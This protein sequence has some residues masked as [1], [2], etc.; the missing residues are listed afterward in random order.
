MGAW[1]AIQKFPKLLFISP[2]ATA[3]RGVL[4]MGLRMGSAGGGLD[5]WSWAWERPQQLGCQG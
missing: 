3:R 2:R 1:A 5:Y 4:F